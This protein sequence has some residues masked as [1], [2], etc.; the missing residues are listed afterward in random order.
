[1]P[2]CLVE[3]TVKLTAAPVQLMEQIA[4]L[5]DYVGTRHAED[6][7]LLKRVRRLAECAHEMID[8]MI[9]IEAE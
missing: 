4:S 3:A 5:C 9:V 6:K 8:T 7:P 2:I 1:M